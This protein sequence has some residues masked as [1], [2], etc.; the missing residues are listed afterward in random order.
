VGARR[1]RCLSNRIPPGGCRH[2]QV[3]RAMLARLAEGRERE[4]DSE[5]VRLRVSARISE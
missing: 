3:M 5:R 4:Q 2:D 1:R